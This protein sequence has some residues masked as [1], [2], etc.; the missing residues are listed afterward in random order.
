MMCIMI[1]RFAK[2]DDA[3]LLGLQDRFRNQQAVL[4]HDISELS[5]KLAAWR[6]EVK[7]LKDKGLPQNELTQKGSLLKV[8]SR[9]PEI[10]ACVDSVEVVQKG[11]P[12]SLND[13]SDMCDRFAS[14]APIKSKSNGMLLYEAEPST[15][16]SFSLRE[17]DLGLKVWGF[18]FI[19]DAHATEDVGVFRWTD[20]TWFAP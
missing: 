16:A 18:G 7:V 11:R 4:V 20:L 10:Q 14:R 17:I 3:Y 9:L 19:L 13:L 12:I 8:V 1:D 5:N 15:K 2:V 6:S